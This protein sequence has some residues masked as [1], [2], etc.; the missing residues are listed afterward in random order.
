[1]TYPPPLDA[2][3]RREDYPSYYAYIAAW[4]GWRI[5]RSDDRLNDE[6]LAAKYDVV[7]EY[8]RRRAE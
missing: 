1:M 2:A 3:P 4:H 7:E 8:V 5:V 6:E